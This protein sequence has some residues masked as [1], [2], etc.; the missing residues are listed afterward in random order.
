MISPSPAVIAPHSFTVVPTESNVGEAV[1]TAGSEEPG[2]R[3]GMELV[4]PVRYIGELNGLEFDGHVV[5]LAKKL[6]AT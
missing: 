5:P 2:G 1:N 3:G 6:S 4:V